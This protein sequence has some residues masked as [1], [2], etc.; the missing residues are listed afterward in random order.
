[1]SSLLW[2]GEKLKLPWSLALGGFGRDGFLQ[3]ASGSETKW[4]KR[5][6]LEQAPKALAGKG[7]A[8]RPRPSSGVGSEQSLGPH[9]DL[10]RGRNNQWAAP[11]PCEQPIGGRGRVIRGGREW[12]FGPAARSPALARGSAM[13]ALSPGE[14]AK[15]GR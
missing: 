1:M 13:T 9:L 14:A 10:E 7:R 4:L 6:N 3:R 2:C 11:V 5:E 15:A 8:C 12:A